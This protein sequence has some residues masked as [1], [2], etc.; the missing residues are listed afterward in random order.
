MDLIV[1]ILVASLQI[2]FLYLSDIDIIQHLKNLSQNQQQLLNLVLFIFT[3]LLVSFIVILYKKQT[4]KRK[5]AAHG[6]TVKIS[7]EEDKKLVQ[8]TTKKA[9]DEL[10]KNPKFQKWQEE[11]NKQLQQERE[12][13]L[14]QQQQQQQQPKQS[15]PI[16]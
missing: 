10:M 7:P 8:E 13:L 16:Q 12:E 11:K 9:L 1:L 4:L 5:I 2:Y 3:I 6:S 14:K 15:Q